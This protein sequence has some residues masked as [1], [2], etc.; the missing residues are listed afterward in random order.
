MYAD[1][2]PPVRRGPANFAGD[3]GRGCEAINL[4]PFLVLTPPDA[5]MQ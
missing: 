5:G 4:V 3:L 1:F 2:G